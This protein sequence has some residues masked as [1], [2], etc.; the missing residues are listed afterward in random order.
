MNPQVI[1]DRRF[2]R[3]L[4][5]PLG[6]VGKA[7]CIGLE[8]ISRINDHGLAIRSNTIM[9][10]LHMESLTV[11]HPPFHAD[12]PISYQSYS[13]ALSCYQK[14][15]HKDSNL[16]PVTPSPLLLSRN[17]TSLNGDDRIRTYTIPE[18]YYR[19]LLSVST[20]GRHPLTSNFP[21]PCHA[22][23]IAHVATYQAEYLE[24]NRD[25]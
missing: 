2:S 10:T 18:L 17:R 11:L 13:D 24:S 7:Q 19:R 6:H 20:I 22:Q 8:P 5:L 21:Y 23:T 1:S 15:N 25:T 14:A 3:P 4:L 16:S 12:E 9:G